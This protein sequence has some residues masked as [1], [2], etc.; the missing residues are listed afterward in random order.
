MTRKIPWVNF[1]QG[2]CP[3]RYIRGTGPSFL[4]VAALPVQAGRV[5][6]SLPLELTRSLSSGLNK[7]TLPAFAL[8]GWFKGLFLWKNANAR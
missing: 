6:E 7:T 3:R 1:C 2:K 8:L 4:R 5:A